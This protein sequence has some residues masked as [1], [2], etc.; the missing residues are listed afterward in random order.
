[1]SIEFME[2]FAEYFFFR[3]KILHHIGFLLLLLLIFFLFACL[4]IFTTTKILIL[5]ICML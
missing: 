4:F 3:L 1:M 5:C 2:N